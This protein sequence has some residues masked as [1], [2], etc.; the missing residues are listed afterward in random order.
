MIRELAD[1]YGKTPAQIVIRWHLDC[2]LVVIRNPSPL[3][4]SRKTLLSGISVSIKMGRGEIIK[5]DQENAS[6]PIRISS[7]DWRIYRIHARRCRR[8]FAIRTLRNNYAR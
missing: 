1:K 7:A 6:A 8:A 3:P 4:V 5:L 2:G